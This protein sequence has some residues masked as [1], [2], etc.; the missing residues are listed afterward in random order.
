MDVETERKAQRG[1]WRA[2]TDPMWVSLVRAWETGVNH[3]SNT[4]TCQLSH[5][6]LLDCRGVF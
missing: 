6:S 3:C 4:I 2:K 5:A 1:S